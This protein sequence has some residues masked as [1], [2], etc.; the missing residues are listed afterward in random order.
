MWHKKI[1]FVGG[2]GGVGKSTSAAAIALQH[3]KNDYKTLLVSTDPAHNVGDLFNCKI[4]GTTKQIARNL[5]ALE[6]DPEVETKIYIETVKKTIQTAVSAKMREE[7]YRQLD[8]VKQSPGVEEAA[9]FDKLVSILLEESVHFD[10]IVIDTAPTGHTVRLLSLPQLMGVW[11]SGLLEKRKITN[12]NYTM[13]LHDGEPVEDPIY[14]ALRNRQNRFQ[15]ASEMLLNEQQTGIVFVMNA[16][17]LPIVETEKA[18]HLLKQYDLTVKAII[19]NKI[20]PND[21]TGEFMAKRKKH[22]VQY[23]KKIKETFTK[24]QIVWIPLFPKDVTT[25][26]EL[27]EFGHYFKGGQY[28]ESIHS[29]K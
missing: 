14:E 8:T 17:R 21:V 11:I 25:E 20:I 3:A 29:S 7:V 15:L 9:L 4:G 22:E 23:I 13:L 24:Q 10:K 12:D 1:L 19:V 18:L 27:I 28:V 16:E 5:F 2:K 6:I 26:L